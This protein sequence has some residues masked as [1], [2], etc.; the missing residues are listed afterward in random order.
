MPCISL[1][2]AMLIGGAVSGAGAIGS[3][4]IGSNAAKE[5]AGVQAKASEKA[6]DS[7]M[8]MFNTV[9]GDLKPYMSIGEDALEPLRGLLGLDGGDA[10][11]MLAAL[12]QTPGYQFTLDQGLKGVQNSYAAKGLGSSGA[13]LKGATEYTTGL[14]Q[15]TY[16]QQLAN[17]FNLAGM[18]QNAAAQT[19]QFGMS[20]TQSANNALLGGATATASGIIG[21]A[22]A[23]GGGLTSAAGSLGNS[24]NMLGLYNS[25]YLDNMLGAKATAIGNPLIDVG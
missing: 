19:G 10:A 3:A 14:A 13:A 21:S 15:Q 20:A 7:T 12:E 8:Q 9:R 25:G 2:T 5:A 4:I 16:Q 18:G 23:I 1:P 24:I 22:N 6:A 11:S 17:Y